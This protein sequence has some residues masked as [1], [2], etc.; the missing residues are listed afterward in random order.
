VADAPVSRQ[1]EQHLNDYYG[2][3]PYWGN[4]MFGHN[5][6]ASAIS[7]PPLFGADLPAEAELLAAPH[8]E[9]Q[10]HLRSMRA[11]TGYHI[12][13]EDGEIG[14]L[15]DF[16]ADDRAWD[17]RYLAINT[18]NW[19][20]GAHV[21]IVPQAVRGFD[22]SDHSVSLALTREAVRGSPP[23]NPDLPIDEAYEARLNGH[24][25]WGVGLEAEPPRPAD[26]V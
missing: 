21:L 10:P 14:H 24:Y 9:G 15:E 7:P 2:W 25:G 6:I 1:M 17:I 23:W 13:A 5:A 19:W 22:W 20:L 26:P 3:D 11:V 12:H 4:Q 18:S 16:Q 8:T